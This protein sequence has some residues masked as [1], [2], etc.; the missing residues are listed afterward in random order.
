MKTHY[1]KRMTDVELLKT[2]K[3]HETIASLLRTAREENTATEYH[4]FVPDYFYE[5][6]QRTG[7]APDSL[8]D[9]CWQT[10]EG[11][12]H[13]VRQPSIFD[14]E[15]SFTVIA[16]KDIRQ[17]PIE[18]HLQCEEGV[19]QAKEAGLFGGKQSIIE[20]WKEEEKKNGTT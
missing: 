10:Q 8:H 4:V 5:A 3:V 14:S 13:I 17:F 9:I 1:Y 19:I 18:R 20:D 11:T 12:A 2:I 7:S 16:T 15:H 6:V